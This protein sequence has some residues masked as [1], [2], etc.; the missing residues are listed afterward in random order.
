[1]NTHILIPIKDIEKECKL[2][3][4]VEKSDFLKEFTSNYKQISLNE[5]DIEEKA[6]LHARKQIIFPATHEEAME[7]SYKKALK[8]FL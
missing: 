8:D 7:Y 3:F 4:L 1:M 5:K 6:K 2:S